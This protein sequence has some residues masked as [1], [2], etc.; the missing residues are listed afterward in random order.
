MASSVSSRRPQLSSRIVLAFFMVS[1]VLTAILY[2]KI[3]AGMF[4]IFGIKD[5]AVLGRDFTNS[6]MIALAMTVATLF[7]ALRATAAHAFVKQVAEELVKVTW[8]TFDESKRNTSSTVWV[9]GLIAMIL[10]AFDWIFGNLTDFLL[11]L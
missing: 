8:P 7:Y 4:T 1:T 3:M 10:F 6:T 5:P 9:T 11:M 2:T